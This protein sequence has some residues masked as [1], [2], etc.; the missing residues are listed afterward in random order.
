MLSGQSSLPN[1]CP[2]CAHSP[3][4]AD[5]CKPNK[6]LR[7]TVKAFIK[8]EEK[9]REKEKAVSA[10]TVALPTH[11]APD[12]PATPVTDSVEPAAEMD[13]VGLKASQSEHPSKS[14]AEPS[15]AA[16]ESGIDVDATGGNDVSRA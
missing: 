11:S 6:N 16:V 9:K 7:L 1:S 10:A 15:H 13:E 3:I 14:A 5:D 12:S 2:V 4:S 8:S